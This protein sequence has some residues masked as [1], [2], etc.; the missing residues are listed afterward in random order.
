MFE[1]PIIPMPALGLITP[2]SIRMVVVLPAPFAPRKP[3]ISPTW[4]DIEI[5]LTAFF[6]PNLFERF[7]RTMSGS[8]MKLQKGSPSPWVLGRW[9]PQNSCSGQNFA[10]S[11]IRRYGTRSSDLTLYPSARGNSKRRYGVQPPSRSKLTFLETFQ[12][13][14]APARISK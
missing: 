4:I 13:K 11:P 7:F 5:L 9:I 1:P 12:V 8:G 10:E 14:P 3:K 2:Q 6:L